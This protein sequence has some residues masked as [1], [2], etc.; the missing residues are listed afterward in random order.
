M[1]CVIVPQIKE[2][3]KNYDVANASG[4]CAG[5]KWKGWKAKHR[6]LLSDNNEPTTRLVNLGNLPMLLNKKQ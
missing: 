6:P 1:K 4:F 2:E 5:E 3:R